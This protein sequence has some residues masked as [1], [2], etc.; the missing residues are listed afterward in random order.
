MKKNEDRRI[1]KTKKA[2][3][4]ALVTL[5]SKKNINDITVSEVTGLADTSRSAFY[6][7]Y[8]DIYA[9]QAEIENEVTREITEMLDEFKP[10]KDEALKFRLFL[11]LLTYVKNNYK[12]GELLLGKNSNRTFWDKLYTALEEHWLKY[13]AIPVEAYGADAQIPYFNSFILSGVV[14][15]VSKW[16]LSG[17]AEPPEKLALMLDGMVTDFISAAML[18]MEAARQ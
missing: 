12:L 2:L 18:R 13:W 1:R 8:Q 17:M 15:V 16:V 9:L 7:H 6:L 3:W 11:S 4:D 5:L 10:D 14:S